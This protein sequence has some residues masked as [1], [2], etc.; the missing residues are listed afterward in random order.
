MADIDGQTPDQPPGR[1]RA[2]RQEGEDAGDAD[3]QSLTEPPAPG[4]TC[5]VTDVE[6][7]SDEV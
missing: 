5:R 1:R 6:R 7:Y 4:V 2:R 3:V